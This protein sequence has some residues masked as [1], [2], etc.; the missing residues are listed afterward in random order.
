MSSFI[1]RTAGA[2]VLTAL[3]GAVLVALSVSVLGSYG[4]GLFVGTPLCLGFVAACLRAPGSVWRADG[5]ALIAT[6]LCGG[7]IVAGGRP[8][9][10]PR[11]LGPPPPPLPRR[12]GPSPPRGGLPAP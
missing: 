11:V 4:W 12:G 9:A 7:L 2:G 6:M 10:P 3:L 1:G 8:R 5:A